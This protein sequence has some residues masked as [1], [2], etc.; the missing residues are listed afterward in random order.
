HLGARGRAQPGQRRERRDR[1]V[2]GGVP[3]V[4]DAVHRLHVAYQDVAAGAELLGGDVVGPQAVG[5]GAAQAAQQRGGGVAL[6]GRV[7]GE[8]E[9]QLVEVA[10][11][12]DLD[13]LGEAASPLGD[14]QDGAAAGVELLGEVDHELE[15]GGAGRG[16]DSEV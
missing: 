12:R 14:D 11:A 8:G 16:R 5:A 13:Q 6:Q 15:A 2:R 10:T 7:R 4:L 9:D 3:R 1:V